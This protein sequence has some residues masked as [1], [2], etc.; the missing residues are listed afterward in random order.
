MVRHNLVERAASLWAY[1]MVLVHHIDY[2]LTIELGIPSHIR[3]HTRY[4]ILVFVQ[5][6][7]RYGSPR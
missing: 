2:V 3:T 6:M 5:W 7:V 4:L 1:N